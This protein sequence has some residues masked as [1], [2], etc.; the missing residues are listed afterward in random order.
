[1]H[2]QRPW[3][4][5]PAWGWWE[6]DKLNVV[7]HVYNP[8]TER[9]KYEDHKFKVSLGYIV[10]TYLKNQKGRKKKKEH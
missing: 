5:S 6:M 7:V 3:V 9:H 1:V 8:S 2:I 4:L 10:R